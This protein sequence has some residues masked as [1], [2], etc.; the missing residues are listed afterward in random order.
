MKAC[1]TVG[2]VMMAKGG[3]GGKDDKKGG[4]KGGDGGDSGGDDEDQP[5]KVKVD[6]D[7]K[8]TD[9]KSILKNVDEKFEK[10]VESTKVKKSQKYSLPPHFSTASDIRGTYVWLSWMNLTV[11]SPRP[12][13]A[14]V[15][16]HRKALAEPVGPRAGELLRCR[17]PSPQRRKRQC[18]QRDH[19]HRRA[20]REGDAQCDPCPIFYRPFYCLNAAAPPLP[21]SPC[22]SATS[23]CSRRN[24]SCTQRS[25]RRLSRPATSA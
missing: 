21:P 8:G 3:K 2:P 12:G 13:F 25:L 1:K 11:V 18:G 15:D 16:P 5:L 10:T 6:T 24:L 22:R 20:L 17:H 4:K 19:H 23:D 14:G 7:V 9:P